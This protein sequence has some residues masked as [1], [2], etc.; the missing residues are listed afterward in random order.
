M[1]LF[2]QR[3]LKLVL[4]VCTG[5][6][7]SVVVGLLVHGTDVFTPTS[8]GFSF[9][10]F[11]LS[12]ACI[13]AYYHF[14]GL[15]ETITAAVVVSAI[16]FV[17]SLSWITTVNAAIWSFGVNLPIILLAFLFERKLAPFKRFKP[18]VIAALFGAMF[19]LLTLCVAVATGAGLLPASV[20]RQNFLDGLLLGLGL[21]I[22]I[23]A[24]EAIIASI[25]HHSYKQPLPAEK[26]T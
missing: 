5:V 16:Q 23:Q 26:Q 3:A 18:L 24:G 9:L 19:V 12:G 22:G 20:F 6:G 4:L 8:V 2:A 15:Q 14:R 1:K 11:G 13:F 7:G 17:F 21:G 10:S 25:E